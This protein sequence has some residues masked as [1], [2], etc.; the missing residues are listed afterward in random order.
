MMDQSKKFFDE[1]IAPLLKR[2]TLEDWTE[3][4]ERYHREDVQATPQEYRI[5]METGLTP[6][7]QRMDIIDVE[8]EVEE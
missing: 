7:Q 4:I 1:Y 5:M 6:L 3:I 2:M 8:W